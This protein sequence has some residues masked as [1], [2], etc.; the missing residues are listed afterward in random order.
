[1]YPVEL[2]QPSTL[3]PHERIRLHRLVGVLFE[4]LSRKTFVHPVIIDASTNVILDGH[5]R[6]KV[7]QLLGLAA[8]PC[9]C[10][11][12]QEDNRI[13]LYPRRKAVPVTK[14]SVI[15]AGLSKK[16]FPPK[17]TRHHFPA[18]PETRIPLENL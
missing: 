18:L 9:I 12:Y 17:T 6:C 3:R 13:H 14:K 16:R 8:I 1:M 2:R 5:H 10:V 4:L 11:P 15:E 7:A